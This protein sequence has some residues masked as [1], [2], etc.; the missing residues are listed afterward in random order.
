[1]LNFLDFDEKDDTLSG[2]AS[3][4]D[5]ATAKNMNS[6]IQ[7]ADG[8][9]QRPVSRVNLDTGRPEPVQGEGTNREAL[10]RFAKLL[11]DERKMRQTK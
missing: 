1:M 3:A 2:D 10:T 8:L 6:L 5:V 11:S 4:T 9:L 7:I